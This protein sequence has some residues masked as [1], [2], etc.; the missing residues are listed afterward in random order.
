MEQSPVESTERTPTLDEDPALG[1]SHRAKLEIL[2]AVL[3]AL[4]LGALDQTIVGTALPKIVTQLGGNEVYNWVFTIYLLTSTITVP[5]YGKLSDLYGRK[6]LLM[7]G[8]TIFLIGSA[9]SGLSQD[10]T[11]LIL[12][13]GIQ[14][15]GAGALFPISLAV[16]G[17]LFTPQ[18]RGKYQGLFGAVFGLS[19]LLG[20]ALGGYI[21]DN[22]GWHWIFYVNIPIG[23]ISL[24]VLAR[25]LPT[26]KRPDASR[27]LDYAGA[28]VFTVAISSLL[29]GLSN[30][31]FTNA[32][33]GQLHEWTDPV[34][35]GLILVGVVLSAIFLVI[36]SRAKEPIVPLDLW[37]IRT[38]AASI[39]AT[40]L[41][42][43]GFFGAIVFLPRWF[44]FVNGSSA[45][46]SGYQ[47]LPL[48]AG[49][50]ISSIIAGVLVSRTGRY[51]IIVLSGLVLMTLGLYLMTGLHADTDLPILWLWMFITG[52][53]IGP[54]LSVFTIVVQNAVPFR[55]LGVAT[56]NLTFFRQIGGSIGLAIT[57]TVFG[58][59]LGEQIP[60]QM[61]KADVPQPIISQFAATGSSGLDRLVGVGQDLGTQILA[62]VPE[63]FRTLVEPYIGQIVRAIHEGFT[64][65]VTQA[66]WVG[67]VAT[68]GAL[69]VGFGLKEIPLRTHHGEAPGPAPEAAN[70]T[71]GGRL[72]GVGSTD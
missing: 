2:G 24:A 42:S 5:F 36:E 39:G 27:N 71:A 57:G 21:T 37:R 40:M 66:F 69:V 61:Q 22:F 43:F 38:Y 30:K 52:L 32:A 25:L 33:T 49:L 34:V 51:K 28:A 68:I 26:V 9:L 44:Q 16:I 4:F 18:E 64:I 7:I 56:S 13:R 63:Q 19:S 3:L 62:A 8:V 58:T 10:I 70:A 48:L 50:I 17:D 11:Q 41:I 23:I 29:L 55:Q 35:G 47:V 6:P 59:A 20:P 67:V 31:G 72:T 60:L 12:F 15:I 54:T 1:L 46:E 65:A 45:T 14:G 53:G